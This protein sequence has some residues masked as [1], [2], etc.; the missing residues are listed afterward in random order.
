MLPSFLSTPDLLV[1]MPISLA[2]LDLASVMPKALF[3][4]KEKP[5]FLAMGC[6][7]WLNR[8]QINGCEC[9]SKYN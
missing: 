8:I 9:I 1:G 3:H 7:F 4:E 5:K 6:F 2:N